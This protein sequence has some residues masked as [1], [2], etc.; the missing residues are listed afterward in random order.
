M[1]CRLDEAAGGGGLICGV[2]SRYCR[3]E[4]SGRD[5]DLLFRV[6]G[7]VIGREEGGGV[8]VG[9]KLLAMEGR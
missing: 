9:L 2:V 6:G 8:Q 4:G 1:E 7:E 5:G 3:F